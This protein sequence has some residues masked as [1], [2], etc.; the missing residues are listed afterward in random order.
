MISRQRYWGC[1]IPIVYCD[2]CGTVPVPKE[3]LPVLLPEDVAFDGSGN[4][5][6]T[7]E[8]FVHTT[9]PSC[10]AR[11]GG[12]RTRWTPSSIPPGISSAIP[13]RKNDRHPFDP[14]RIREWMP[15]D[16]YIG[17]I[18]H[19]VLHLLYSRFFT[20]VLYDAGLVNVDE[21]F[22]SLLTQGMVLKDGA[23]MSKSKGNTVSPLE[24]ID[25][26]VPTPPACSSCSPLRRSGTWNGA[27]PEWRGATASWAGFSG[28]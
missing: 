20:K 8:S 6:T 5:L 10:G 14:E 16:E 18:E 4:P 23:K 2:G 21:P 24:I 27:T 13:T 22:T 9:C 17:G 15:V 7:S 26:T 28:R 12:R 3:Q 1:P 11:R 19:A 25:G